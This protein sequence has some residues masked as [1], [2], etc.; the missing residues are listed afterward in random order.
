MVLRAPARSGLE[1]D[2]AERALSSTHIRPAAG[3]LR[4]PGTCNSSSAPCPRSTT[5]CA[6]LRAPPG[7]SLGRSAAAVTA[8]QHP[9]RPVACRTQVSSQPPQPAW[10]RSRRSTLYLPPTRTAD[11][12]SGSNLLPHHQNH[13]QEGQ[14]GAHQLQNHALA[15]TRPEPSSSQPRKTPISAAPKHATRWT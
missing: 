12:L 15:C 4:R 9:T 6:P 14:G 10:A 1:P 11:T 7:R 8:L 5:R 3:P 13:K 2:L